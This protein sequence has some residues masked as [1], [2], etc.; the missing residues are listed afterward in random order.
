VLIIGSAETNFPS[1]TRGRSI[2]TTLFLDGQPVGNM[3]TGSADVTD[4]ISFI[5]VNSYNLTNGSHT[6][7]IAFKREA[8]G[9][10]L[11]IN[12]SRAR[13]TVIP[14]GIPELEINDSHI[15]FNNTNPNEY[16]NITINATVFNLG[17]AAARNVL[18]DFWDGINCTGSYIGNRT[19]SPVLPRNSNATVNITYISV[20]GNRTISVCVD[21]YS[22]IREINKT[23]NNASRTLNVKSTSVYYGNLTGSNLTLDNA[24]NLTA[25]DFGFNN[26]GN[27]YFFYA[28]STFNFTS[29]QALGRN[30]TGG[31]TTNDFWDADFNLNSTFFNDSVRRLWANWSNGTPV[32]TRTFEVYNNTIP[33]V[34]IINSTNN[35]IYVTGI[36]WDMDDDTNGQY[37]TTDNE[38]LVF[39]G[40]IN[41]SYT[42]G[43][44]IRVDYEIRIATLLRRLKGQLNKTA[45]IVELQ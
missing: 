22:Y 9:G 18:V 6:A 42:G 25:Y 28:N 44:G 40:T 13:I 41:Q 24:R 4:V 38:D 35:S 11:D 20:I 19:I 33:F 2:T 43:F 32:T 26:S 45:Y 16:E 30:R 39:V 27:I 8:G 5:A 17:R 23:N 34:P 21:P 29:L 1:T 12:I 3:T 7:N 15:V 37:D 14:I 31:A 10:T 36:L